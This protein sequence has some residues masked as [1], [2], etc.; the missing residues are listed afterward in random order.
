MSEEQTFSRGEAVSSAETRKAEL[1]RKL[2]EIFQQRK[3][4]AKG[5]TVQE[6]A[7][8]Q[9]VP[10]SY[11][12]VYM[13]GPSQAP[14]YEPGRVIEVG[15]EATIEYVIALNPVFPFPYPGQNAC[16]ILTSHGDKVELFF[17]TSNTQTME[18]VPALNYHVCIPTTPGQC[19]YTGVW[20]F[21]PPTAACLYEVNCCCRICNCSNR[22]LPQYSGFV[23]WV[24][25]FDYEWLFR[26]P[27]TFDHPIRY[28]VSDPSIPCECY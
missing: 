9:L 8:P 20:T 22:A 12:D 6:L 25:N 26:V 7:G 3:A 10:I 11:W 17:F 4:E 24:E 14:G 18:P 2:E 1:D 16:D 21:R 5:K 23:R 19:W 15:E 13:R 27:W 28:M